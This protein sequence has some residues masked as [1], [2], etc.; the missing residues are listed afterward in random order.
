MVPNLQVEINNEVPH[1]GGGDGE[2]VGAD[3][4][5]VVLGYPWIWLGKD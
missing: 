2:W 3:T 1:R 4:E 5:V